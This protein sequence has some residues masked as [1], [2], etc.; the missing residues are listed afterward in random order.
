MLRLGTVRFEMVAGP[1]TLA[2]EDLEFSDCVELLDRLRVRKLP[3]I[4]SAS[5]PTIAEVEDKE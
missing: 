5:Q 2:G 1:A 4:A 3:A